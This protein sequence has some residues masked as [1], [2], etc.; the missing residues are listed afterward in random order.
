VDDVES[1]S[2]FIEVKKSL[3]ENP[4]EILYLVSFAVMVDRTTC[5]WMKMYVLWSSE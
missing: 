1:V 5:L 2:G 3:R 4:N